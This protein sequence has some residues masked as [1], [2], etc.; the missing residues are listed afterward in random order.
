MGQGLE[1]PAEQDASRKL[2]QCKACMTDPVANGQSEIFNHQSL[3]A[4]IDANGTVVGHREY[5]PDGGKREYRRIPGEVRKGAKH[6]E[7]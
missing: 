3:A 6:R 2:F 1:Y 4:S 7:W 5:G